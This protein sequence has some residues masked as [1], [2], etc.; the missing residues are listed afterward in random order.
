MTPRMSFQAYTRAQGPILVHWPAWGGLC[1]GPHCPA[2]HLSPCG[3]SAPDILV[4][5]TKTDASPQP[6]AEAVC[7]LWSLFLISE[8]RIIL[9]GQTPE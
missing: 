2:H 9:Q 8:T 1:L 5:Q 3:A 4:G 6:A 7:P